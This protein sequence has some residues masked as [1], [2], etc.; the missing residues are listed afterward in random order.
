MIGCSSPELSRKDM[1]FKDAEA[2]VLKRVDYPPSAEFIKSEHRIFQMRDN[3][4]A[5][6]ITIVVDTENGRGVMRRDKVMY[7]YTQT[8]KDSLNLKSYVVTEF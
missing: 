2:R 6:R 8:G 1:L 4:D 5:Y 3:K 7:L